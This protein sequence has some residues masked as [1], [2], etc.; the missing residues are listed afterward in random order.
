MLYSGL[1]WASITALA[2]AAPES[3]LY[4]FGKDS[5]HTDTKAPSISANTARLLLAQRLGL[6]T[7]HELG[8]VDDHTFEILNAYGSN[9]QTLFASQKDEVSPLLIIEGVE[10]P[11]GKS[12]QT[13]SQA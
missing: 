11:E 10:R 12:R 2:S 6:S 4:I 7:Y 5:I 3:L 8:N 13:R 9:R 1:I